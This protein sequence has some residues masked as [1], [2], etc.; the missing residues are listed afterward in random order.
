MAARLPVD[1]VADRIKSCVAESRVTLVCGNTGSGKS[2]RVPGL[3]AS[4]LAGC[5][6][7]TMPRR[8]AATSA[9]A[10]CA[11]ECG[12]DVG[13]D[14]V[15]F[16]IGSERR[17]HDATR[18][19]FATAGV[20]VEFIRAHGEMALERW[21]AIILDEVHERSAESDLALALVRMLLLRRPKLRLVLMSATFDQKRYETYFADDRFGRVARVA[22]PD[23]LPGAMLTFHRS[24]A[25]YLDGVLRLPGLE[26][27]ADVANAPTSQADSLALPAGLHGVICAL[28]LHLHKNV[29]RSPKE[30][31]LVFLPTYRALEH[32]YELL[33]SSG[34]D[35]AV[36]ALHSAI[37]METS[38]RSIAEDED[39]GT[40]GR[41]VLL[42]TNVAESSLTIPGVTCVVD[43]CRTLQVVWNRAEQRDVPAVRWISKSQADQRKGR[44]G[45]TC[46]G[47]C[48]RLVT[49]AHY[50][51]LAAYEPPAL[52]SSSLREAA[53]MLSCSAASSTSDPAALLATCLDPPERAHV[54]DALA[55]LSSIDAVELSISGK[56]RPTLLGRVLAALPLTLSAARLAVLG[57]HEGFARDAAALAAV[58]DKSPLPITQ[59]FGDA[60][61]CTANLQRFVGHA[62]LGDR[63]S[64]I[65]AN[66][67]AYEFWQRC[68]RDT[69]RW[70]LLCQLAAT[71]AAAPTPVIE[72][73]DAAAE[74][75]WCASHR[76]SYTALLQIEAVV[77]GVMDALHKW[78]PAFLAQMD[79]SGWA[80]EGLAV[81]HG[82]SGG[83]LCALSV[84]VVAELFPKELA[85]KLER[86]L[87]T[88]T[89][90]EE[91]AIPL[92]M[93]IPIP[94]PKPGGAYAEASS[95]PLCLFFKRPGGCTRVGCRFA[96]VADARPPDCKFFGTRVGCSFGARCAYYHDPRKA[97]LQTISAAPMR[98]VRAA[99]LL[100]RKDAPL[101]APLRELLDDASGRAVLLLGEGDF[102]FAE[103]LRRVSQLRIVAT[104]LLSRADVEATYAGAA[105]R[106]AR[107]EAA[108]V[109]LLH[110]VDA[111]RL[112]RTPA[113]PWADV[114]FVIFNH[115]A[116][117]DDDAE[118]NRD[119]LRGFFRAATVAVMSNAAD[120]LPE[121]V[122]VTLSNDQ[123]S[124]WGLDGLVREAL[125]H[126]SYSWPL[127]RSLFPG[128][129][130]L[131][132]F[133]EPLA[134]RESVTFCM[135]VTGRSID[136][137]D[138]DCATLRQLTD[139]A[140]C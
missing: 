115:P 24:S 43:S 59:P 80:Y 90:Q 89:A 133:D 18:V 92:A 53:L 87:C 12:A 81:E 112:D 7:C 58:L 44:T 56:P 22:I 63:V 23:E 107:L 9:A 49:R 5:V 83:D 116:A 111:T 135:E 35:F 113:I 139:D 25:E 30:V 74:E 114:K 72:P 137:F 54:L 91:T 36:H 85:D 117:D 62:R 41:K 79:Y 108:G 134:E 51:T 100:L 60:A 34:A 16:H 99:D 26:A 124:R 61:A 48:Y 128:Y 70:A 120:V 13:G 42:A 4:A 73:P 10:R 97:P 126:C 140:N 138:E 125:M 77:A 47:T 55:F 104:S 136:T 37:D 106:L 20:L 11:S 2:T 93:P 94:V 29:C 46:A 95:A 57:G 39:G 88:I 65:M 86:A 82:C 69:R 76:L 50:D 31:I 98:G 3:V 101:A 122:F 67:A 6:L 84:P 68:R 132:N 123:A 131:R 17:C 78:R 15:G 45:R 110:G 14:E 32:Q 105:A 129:A 40:Q 119:L 21:R 103:A 96:H 27:F 118:A 127:E 71:P 64:V 52:R 66:L 75:R 33:V 1:L 130:P 121:Y 19:V 102:S 28:V 8:L 38:A 109:T